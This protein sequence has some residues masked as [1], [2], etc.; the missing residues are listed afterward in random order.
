MKLTIASIQVL[1]AG[2][3]VCLELA[4]VPG[5]SRRSNQDL[6]TMVDSV[7]RTVYASIYPNQHEDPPSSRRKLVLTSFC[8]SICTA[9][10]WKQPNCEC[11][12]GSLKALPTRAESLTRCF[13][14]SEDPVFFSSYCGIVPRE[15]HDAEASI[16]TAV[17]DLRQGS[18]SGAV[19]FAK[20]NNLLGILVDAR[21]IVGVP[22]FCNLTAAYHRSLAAAPSSV[23]GVGSSRREYPSG[24]IRFARLSASRS[25]C[26]APESRRDS[27]A[28]RANSA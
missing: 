1:P 22:A 23:F 9:L 24:V 10:N 28:R 12:G 6:N 4:W 17:G 15:S 11:L 7:L 13:L 20:E 27:H 14:F 25:R 8:P 5:L 18:I 26:G 3:G 16:E 2:L 19:D 21:L